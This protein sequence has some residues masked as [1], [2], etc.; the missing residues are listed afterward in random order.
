VGQAYRLAATKP[1]TGAFNI[2]ADPVLDATSIGKLVGAR[3][4]QLA[5]SIVR[6]AA[7]A[8]WKLRLQP[9]SPGWLDMGMLSPIMDVRRAREELGWEPLFSAGATLGEL[10]D[11]LRDG[12][13]MQTPPLDPASSG[14]LR[15]REFATGIG[16]IDK[17]R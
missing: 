11:G 10:L 13:G 5:P 15:S 7:L 6:G 4:L 2:A 1:V 17:L 14:P 9:T 16:A 3:P 8:S 12:A